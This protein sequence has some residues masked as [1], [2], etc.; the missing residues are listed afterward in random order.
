MEMKNVKR[1]QEIEMFDI[2]SCQ[3]TLVLALE[4]ADKDGMVKV[5]AYD[6]YTTYP[7]YDKEEDYW[8]ID[9]GNLGD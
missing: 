9:G 4:D 7:Q 1:G 8:Y 6:A 3:K 5:E 2:Y